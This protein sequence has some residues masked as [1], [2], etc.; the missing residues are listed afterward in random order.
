MPHK[1]YNCPYCGESWTPPE[2]QD[3]ECYECGY[4]NPVIDPPDALN[5]MDN[6]PELCDTMGG[7]T[8]FFVRKSVSPMS[9]SPN[10]SRYSSVFHHSP[11]TIN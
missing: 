1:Y 6:D 2:I 10:E 5:G 8:P 11:I 4:P 9:E 7:L 3:Q